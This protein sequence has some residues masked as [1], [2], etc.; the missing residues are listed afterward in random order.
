MSQGATGAT[1]RVRVPATTANIGPG[2]DCLGL[3]LDL[4]NEVGFSLEGEGIVVSVEV[5][6]NEVGLV[7]HFTTTPV[8]APPGLIWSATVNFVE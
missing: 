6:A 7:P 8:S 1:C 4:W 5:C 3:A 2:F